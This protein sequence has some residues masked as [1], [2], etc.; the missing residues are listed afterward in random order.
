MV[1][2][3]YHNPRCRKSREALE[4]LKSKGLDPSVRL[5]LQDPPSREELEHLLASLGMKASELIR[6]EETLFKELAAKSQPDED[7]CLH[8]MCEHPNL[9]QRPVVVMGSRAVVARPPERL[10]EITG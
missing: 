5:Y 1:P 3:I 2:L 6:R 8:W 10:L 7:Q 9:V 4:L